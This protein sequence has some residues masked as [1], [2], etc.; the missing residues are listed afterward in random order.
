MRAPHSRA[1]LVTRDVV[2]FVFW[3]GVA[4]G[5]AWLANLILPGIWL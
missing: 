3:V 4:Y 2:R 5:V 1:Y